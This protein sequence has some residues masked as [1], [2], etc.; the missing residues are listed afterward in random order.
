M[1]ELPYFPFYVSDFATDGKVEAM[2]TAAV[3]AYILLLCKAWHETP[4][5]SIPNDDAVLARWAR[6]SPHDWA[7]CRLSVLSCFRPGPDNRLYQKRM[8]DEYRKLRGIRK[9][10]SDAANA[11]WRKQSKSNANGYAHALQT[12]SGSASVSPGSSG[13]GG[14]GGGE[15]HTDPP[16]DRPS[17]SAIFTHRID[18]DAVF[19][20]LPQRVQRRINSFRTSFAGAVEKGKTPQEIQSA[21]EAYYASPEGAGTHFRQPHTFLD[22][23]GWRESPHTWAAREAPAAGGA[24][25]PARP[26]MSAEE[27]ERTFSQ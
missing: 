21:L 7:E 13:V 27:I 6:M 5:G 8:Q 20:G 25:R 10:R 11:R 1:K 4:P 14:A 2:S 9:L 22:E 23:E 19:S 12:V 26:A 24:K 17:S 15:P 18:A 3:G 16:P